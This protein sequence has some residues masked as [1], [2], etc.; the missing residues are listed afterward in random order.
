MSASVAT[1]DLERLLSPI[2]ADSPCGE[3]LRWDPVWDE[4]SQL[5]KTWKDPLD[6]SADKLP[7][8]PKVIDVAS[9]TLATRTK[10]LLIARHEKLMG[11]GKFKEIS[12]AE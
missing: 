11:Y 4:L 10:D 6:A 1:L 3:S 7:E 8:W 2:A 12:A 9:Q 5:R